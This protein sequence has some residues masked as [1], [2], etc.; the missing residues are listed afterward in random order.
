MPCYV[1]LC[2][3]MSEGQPLPLTNAERQRRYRARRHDQ[4]PV[5]RYRRP[6]DRR[7]R[8]QRWADAVATPCCVGGG[9]G[10]TPGAPTRLS[11]RCFFSGYICNDCGLRRVA[12]C[13]PTL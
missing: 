9:G 11:L 13:K 6:E 10:V 8:P 12:V 5:V 2:I 3:S 4:Q 7:T 1:T